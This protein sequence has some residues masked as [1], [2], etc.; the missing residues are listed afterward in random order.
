TDSPAF[1][2]KV[3]VPAG[4]VTAASIVFAGDTTGGFMRQAANSPCVTNGTKCIINLVA[5]T[6]KIQM[7]SNGLLAFSNSSSDATTT[8]N[9]SVNSAGPGLVGIGTGATQ[10]T[11][12]IA[13]GMKTFVTAD[14]TTAAN[15]S[16]QTITGLSWTLPVS[17]AVNFSFHCALQYSQGTA[18]GAVAFGVQ[19]ATTAPTQINASGI[20]STN[21]TAQTYGNLQG[22]ATTTATNVVSAT[23]SAITTIWNAYLDG[24]V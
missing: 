16:L 17:T 11:G 22:L 4:S 12:L 18:T 6:P 1:T 14:F 9:T 2:T 24:T 8:A 15:T 7:P 23:P 20:I 19:G 10:T 3:T 21:T 5:G 13:S